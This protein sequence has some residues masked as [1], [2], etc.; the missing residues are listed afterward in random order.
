MFALKAKSGEG[1]GG[2]E[3]EG[4]GGTEGEGSGTGE[5]SGSGT[6]GS[7][8]E[9]DSDNQG[10]H[11]GSGGYVPPAKM[12]LTAQ[13][14]AL[15]VETGTAADNGDA[16][17]DGRDVAKSVSSAGST[18]GTVDSGADGA[19]AAAEGAPGGVNP[20]AVGGIALGVVGLACAVAYVAR[21]KRRAGGVS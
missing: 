4:S 2:T 16:V 17:K 7:T 19:E 5:G 12:P 11:G 15:Q 14:K 1:S 10:N 8:G 6:E 18:A 3:G 21:S 13:A 9:G 20:W